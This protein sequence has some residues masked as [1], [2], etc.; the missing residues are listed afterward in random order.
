MNMLQQLV[1]VCSLH[2]LSSKG[3]TRSS[4]KISSF[5]L[6]LRTVY[7]VVRSKYFI[8]AVG[9]LFLSH[10]LISQ[11]SLL[12]KEWEELMFCTIF[13]LCF[14]GLNSF[15]VIYL[16]VLAFVKIVLSWTFL[17]LDISQKQ[18]DGIKQRGRKR[19]CKDQEE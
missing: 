11:I 17:K 19:Q 18:T 15:S 5:L 4:S 2:H 7:P 8:S 10:S 13:I 1:P 12:F 9:S 14:F 3:V 16:K 6:W